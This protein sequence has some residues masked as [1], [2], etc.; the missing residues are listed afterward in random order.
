M[1]TVVRPKQTAI[2][3]V[4]ATAA[5]ITACSTSVSSEPETVTA[6]ESTNS[7]TETSTEENAANS[8]EAAPATFDRN[9]P[10]FEFFNICEELTNED[11]APEG[12]VFSET[13]RSVDLSVPVSSC[14][15]D[16][17]EDEDAIQARVV[18]VSGISPDE[19]A[20]ATIPRTANVQSTIP[21]TQIFVNKG[22]EEVTACAAA[23]PT[24]GGMLW[25][26]YENFRLNAI[27]G[28]EACD[29]AVD[30]LQQ[31]HQILEKRQ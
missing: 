21:G 10:N 3:I 27:S 6:T 9:D 16:V 13:V 29:K 24:T 12:L 17:K 19:L 15:F 8:T 30:H 26:S 23:A 1:T 20:D 25:I 31:F 18:A 7:A 4:T 28:E 11:L 5:F 22:V 14:G 2:A